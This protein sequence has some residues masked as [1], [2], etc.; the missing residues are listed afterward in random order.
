MRMAEIAG[1]QLVGLEKPRVQSLNLEA[2]R[3]GLPVVGIATHDFESLVSRLIPLIDSVTKQKDG[4][5]AVKFSKEPSWDSGVVPP[6][7]DVKA[8]V[9]LVARSAA[10]MAAKLKLS[11]GE[12]DIAT[13]IQMRELS[14][15]ATKFLTKNP[16]FNDAEGVK[17]RRPISVVEA[18]RVDP[19]YLL[20]ESKPVKSKWKLG[21]S[22]SALTAAGITCTLSSASPPALVREINASAIFVGEGRP[23]EQV[24]SQEG[25]IS[26]K[27]INRS[28]AD[29]IK[30]GEI[31]VR[32]ALPETD[33]PQDLV[34]KELPPAYAVGPNVNGGLLFEQVAKVQWVPNE[35]ESGF[36]IVQ[37]VNPGE[38][39]YWYADGNTRTNGNV[40]GYYS[41]PASEE[42]QIF[43][44]YPEGVTVDGKKGELYPFPPNMQLYYE[45]EAP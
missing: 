3:A 26:S 41:V 20:S 11:G 19:D 5:L 16:W 21:V 29:A 33:M 39:G 28:R 44:P 1:T 8:G 36:N 31:P 18:L 13:T 10:Y 32:Y 17:S 12:A 30:L 45:I 42:T 24:K 6:S 43:Q 37:L 25:L 22:L 35:D 7:D 15:N 14:V 4:T 23:T 27:E 38:K 2:G 40:A 9:A 34:R